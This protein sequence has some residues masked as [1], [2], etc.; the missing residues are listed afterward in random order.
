[1]E[2]KMRNDNTKGDILKLSQSKD[3]IT[4]VKIKFEGR[5]VYKYNIHILCF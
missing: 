4:F 2:R 1:M 3:R 5:A